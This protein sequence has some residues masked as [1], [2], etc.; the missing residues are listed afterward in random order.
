MVLGGVMTKDEGKKAKRA[1]RSKV[2]TDGG[3]C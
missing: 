2:Q 3:V 1:P